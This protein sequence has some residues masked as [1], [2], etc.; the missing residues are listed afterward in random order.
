VNKIPVGAFNNLSE[1]NAK[2]VV[3]PVLCTFTAVNIDT[4]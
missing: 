4:K 3:L 1:I 2:S